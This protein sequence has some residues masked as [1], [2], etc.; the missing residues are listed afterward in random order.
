MIYNPR[1]PDF[2]FMKCDDSIMFIRFAYK[3]VTD[4]YLW[5]F[6]YNYNM[7]S[8]NDVIVFNNLKYN[9]KISNIFHKEE[10]LNWTMDVILYIAKNGFA[11][12]KQNYQIQY[13]KLNK[14]TLFDTIKDKFEKRIKTQ[15]A[16]EI[17]SHIITQIQSENPICEF[18]L[19]C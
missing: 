7:D 17:D 9:I 4:E 10:S 1:D 18:N 5:E 6:L 2:S 8:N 19:Y 14:K 12:Y 13:E 3:I 15:I 11:K 16:Q